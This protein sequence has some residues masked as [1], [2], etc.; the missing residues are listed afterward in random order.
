M[1]E[2]AT[3][4]GTSEVRGWLDGENG[5]DAMVKGFFKKKIPRGV[6]LPREETDGHPGGEAKGEAESGGSTEYEGEEESD[7]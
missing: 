3:D 4:E 5:K 6:G 1:S 2:G 7:N